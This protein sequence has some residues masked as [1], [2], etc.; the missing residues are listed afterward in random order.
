[1]SSRYWNN[2]YKDRPWEPKPWEPKSCTVPGNICDVN[3]H[4]CFMKFEKWINRP[5][6]S[7]RLY[8]RMHKDG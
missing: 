3:T 5:D 7:H 8:W 4:Q 6:R 1:M 2:Y